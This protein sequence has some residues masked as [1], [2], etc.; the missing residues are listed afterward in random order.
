MASVVISYRCHFPYS[1]G[2][3]RA[4]YLFSKIPA[5]LKGKYLGF[6]LGEQEY[7]KVCKQVIEMI[8]GCY[9]DD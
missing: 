5:F 6:L 9:C 2:I 8:A 4:L 1:V 3:D 7:V